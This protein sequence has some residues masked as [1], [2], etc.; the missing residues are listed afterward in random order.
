[1]AQNEIDAEE[2]KE[3]I[4]TSSKISFDIMYG[5]GGL[6]TGLSYLLVLYVLSYISVR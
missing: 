1:M 4:S 2:D 5:F 6:V 3:E